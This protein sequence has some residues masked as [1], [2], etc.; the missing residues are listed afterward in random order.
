MRHMRRNN[1]TNS[2]CVTFNSVL[3]V[4]AELRGLQSTDIR[5]AFNMVKFVGSFK[6]DWCRVA[7]T[8]KGGLLR[9]TGTRGSVAALF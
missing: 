7:F 8:S 9:S 4:S 6:G 3:D 5:A 2:I 1:K